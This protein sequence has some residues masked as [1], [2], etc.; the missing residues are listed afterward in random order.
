[1]KILSTTAAWTATLA[2]SSSLLN[3]PRFSAVTLWVRALG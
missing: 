2:L 1:M 3:R